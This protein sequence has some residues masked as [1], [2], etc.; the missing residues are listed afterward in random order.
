MDDIERGSTETGELANYSDRTIA[1]A[2]NSEY[3]GRMNDPTGSAYVVGQ[4]GDEMEFY[5]V[6]G[7]GIIEE[8]RYYTEGCI[9]TRA[10]GAVTAE[11]ATGKEIDE[12][13]C[14]SPKQVKEILSD[15]P[16]EQSHCSILAVIALYKAIADYL[17]R[18]YSS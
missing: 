2:T 10:C 18:F 6:I 17:L 12:A 4:C 11:L 16:E 1:L 3:S 9:S 13:L 15:L 7:D 5:L 14:I 8:A